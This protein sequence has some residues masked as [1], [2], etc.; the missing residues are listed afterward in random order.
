MPP[1]HLD[2]RS[3][4]KKKLCAS[5]IFFLIVFANLPAHTRNT[6]RW[7]LCTHNALLAK[8]VYF[9]NSFVPFFLL[10]FFSPLSPMRFLGETFRTCLFFMLFITI[11]CD[12]FFWSFTT[13][14]VIR[15]TEKIKSTMAGQTHFAS[16][17]YLRT[18]SERKPC[19]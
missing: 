15:W 9:A 7:F 13:G 14:S 17:F 3:H 19:T 18:W 2:C 12:C 11:I 8:Q 4:K 10:I 6:L 1:S 16:L 5:S